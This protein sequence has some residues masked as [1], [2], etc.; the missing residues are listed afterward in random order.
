MNGFANK[1]L[2]QLSRG[3]PH[4]SPPLLGEGIE[5]TPPPSWGGSGRGLSICAG[6][7]RGDR[8][9]RGERGQSLVEFAFTLPILLLLILGTIDL[10]LGFRT[11]IVL[12]NAAREGARWVSVS[13]C[14]TAGALGRISLEAGRV[15]LSEGAIGSNSYT[16]SFTPNK[17]CYAAGETVTVRVSHNFQLMFG[18]LTGIPAVP[19]S[20]QASMMVL[21]DE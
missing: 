7:E 21:Y 16:P 4:P 20:A 6:P 8:S 10:G 12:T 14:D 13:P 18:T 3:T 1:H 2:S 15:G 17:T 19:F 5:P 11:Y 9:R